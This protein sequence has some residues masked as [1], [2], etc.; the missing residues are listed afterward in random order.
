MQGFDSQKLTGGLS[1]YIRQEFQELE[2]L[3]EITKLRFHA[4]LPGQVDRITRAQ[5]ITSY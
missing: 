1:G 5:L 3:D 4:N 2:I